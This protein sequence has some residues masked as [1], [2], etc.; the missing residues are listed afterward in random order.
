MKVKDDHIGLYNFV[1][2]LF[3]FIHVLGMK[4]AGMHKSSLYHLVPPPALLQLHLK[5]AF[6][7][8]HVIAQGT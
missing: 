3:S 2:C 1:A 8:L 6:I 4:V 7:Q 5:E